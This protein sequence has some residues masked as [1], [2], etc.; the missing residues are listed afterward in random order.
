MNSSQMNIGVVAD[1]LVT[2]QVQKRLFKKLSIYIRQLHYI[3]LSTF[4]QKMHVASYK[5]RKQTQHSYKSFQ[6]Q[7]ILIR[8]TY[9]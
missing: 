7:K 8:N 9:L 2:L 3:Q 4:C 1:W 6:R 5:V